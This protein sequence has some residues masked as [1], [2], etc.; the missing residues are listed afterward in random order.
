MEDKKRNIKL[1]IY[2]GIFLLAIVII[3]IDK[4]ASP[5]QKSVIKNNKKEETII[6][7]IKEID[8]NYYQSNI[9]LTFEDDAISLE[10]EKSDNIEI[11]T[12]K[13]H[14]NKENYIKY[15]NNYYL[16]ENGEF[17]KLTNFTEF[18][19]DQTFIKLENIQKVLELNGNITNKN[20]NVVDLTEITYN[21]KDLLKIYNEYNNESIIAYEDS[22]SSLKIYH[23]DKI[24]E[25]IE[26]DI[27]SLY[28][29]INKT[30]KEK[31][32][33]TLS[34]K[35]TKKEDNSWLIEKLP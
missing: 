33:L 20:Y 16:F 12:K 25:K 19:Y 32:L 27:T 14:N 15:N 17:T 30:E 23:K 9:S 6:E 5:S 3:L 35:E 21:N 4:A 8:P 11:G 24:I 26:F 31:V 2:L 13:Y 34:F 7:Q 22:E 29:T 18:D 1:I 10:Y 28:N